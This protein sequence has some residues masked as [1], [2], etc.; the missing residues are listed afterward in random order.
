MTLLTFCLAYLSPM[1]AGRLRV[2]ID[3]ARR[4]AAA[5]VLLDCNLCIHCQPRARAHTHTHTHSPM[6]GEGLPMFWVTV[7]RNTGQLWEAVTDRDEV[8]LRYLSDVK[9]TYT[10]KRAGL[11]EPQV[12]GIGLFWSL[13]GLSIGIF[14]LYIRSL[15][16]LDRSIYRSLLTFLFCIPQVCEY[17][18]L[19]LFCSLIDL[20]IGLFWQFCF[21]YR[22][23]ATSAINCIFSVECVLS[24]MHTAGLR[25]SQGTP[26]AFVQAR[27]VF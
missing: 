19:G 14:F 25:L 9:V 21:A 13:I 10:D 12:W 27:A 26:A 4:G 8:A 22:R 6:V 2:C 1:V 17:L 24:K 18:I 23:I 16:L 15:L 11:C 3:A 7:L 5:Y 20:F